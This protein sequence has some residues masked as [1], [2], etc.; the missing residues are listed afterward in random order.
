MTCLE[1]IDSAISNWI[2]KE[3]ELDGLPEIN[4]EA[5][6][7]VVLDALIQKSDLI[8]MSV[9]CDRELDISVKTAPAEINHNRK[10]ARVTFTMPKTS[11]K[12]YHLFA[13]R[14]NAEDFNKVKP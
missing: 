4:T 6:A 1:T 2:Y 5:L 13:Y 10:G 14:I 9:M 3:H 11:I 8:A 12:H 7:K